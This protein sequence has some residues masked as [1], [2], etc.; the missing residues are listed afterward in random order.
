MEE[1]VKVKGRKKVKGTKKSEIVM[2]KI[3]KICSKVNTFGQKKSW[4]K[5][6]TIHKRSYTLFRKMS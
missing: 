4:T 5:K 1:R 2:K 6:S 3:Q